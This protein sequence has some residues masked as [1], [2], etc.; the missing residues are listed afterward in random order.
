MVHVN[1]K[2]PYNRRLGAL[3]TER[4]SF[5]DHWRD[6]SEYLLPRRGRFLITEKNKGDKKNNKIIDNEG[7]M[8]LNTLVSGL[9][10][11]VTSPA[12]KWFR[13]AT[14]DREMMDYGPVKEW[15]H[16]VE[17]AA[18]EVFQQSNFYQVMPYVYE[19]M[20]A[21]GTASMIQL[22]DFDTVSRFQAFTVG[23]Y[24]IAQDETYRVNS[25]YR[26]IPMTVEQIVGRY[27]VKG[28]DRREIDWSNI[29]AEVKNLWDRGQKD[30]WINIV[31]LI[32]PNADPDQTGLAEDMPW[33]SVA[34]EI[35]GQDDLLLHKGGFTRFPV[36]APR[37]HIAPPDI[38]GR[39]PGME[40][41]GDLRQ[42]QDQQKKKGSAIAKM[43]N[44]P[45]VASPNMKNQRL[46]TLPGDVTFA[47]QTDGTGGFTPAYQV[48]PRLQD[49]QID[50]QDVRERIRRAFFSD[51]FLMMAQTDNRQPITAEEVIERRSEKLLVLGPV[52]SRINH[53]LLD[54]LVENTFARMTE[55]D[56]L[57]EAPPELQGQQLKIEYISMLANAQKSQDILGIQDTASF[58]GGLASLNPDVI[59]KFDFDQAVDEFGE[60]RGLPPNV[61]RADDDVENIR[62]EKAAAQQA[63]MQQAQMADAAAG[64]KVLSETSTEEGNM[65]GDMLAGVGSP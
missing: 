25:I 34:F 16:K 56:M 46:S 29:S 58:V 54:P 8:A 20:G 47:A 26:E 59:D 24:C 33:C 53:D 35:G 31:H 22:D 27:G 9:M 32:E 21:F 41:L 2:E 15:L 63:Q 1:R 62:A 42:L 4:Q 57:P 44:P 38:Y 10:S 37:W 55:V 6:L 43:V 7:T 48:Q 3:K 61:I 28:N 12:R 64:A 18:Y 36:Y 39:S 45:M 19:E 52:L 50:M 49:F 14:P 51:L 17:L 13:L 30:N 40:S 60:A 5:I 65:L 11:G 23:E